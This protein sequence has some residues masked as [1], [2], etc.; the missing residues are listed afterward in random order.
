M[1]FDYCPEGYLNLRRRFPSQ[2]IGI[3]IM[4]PSLSV[5]RERLANRGTEC[6]EEMVLRYK[7]ALQDFNFV[8]QHRYHIINDS[9]S[10]SLDQLR[11][12]RVAEH[13]RLDRQEGVLAA[14]AACAQGALLR[15]YDSPSR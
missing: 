14:Y 5:L 12:I 2:V 8:D 7:M 3:F 11:A 4:A 13:C 15:Y 6:E 9:F 1:V 10:A